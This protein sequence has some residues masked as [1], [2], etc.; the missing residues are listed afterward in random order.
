[1]AR[2]CGGWRNPLDRRV[3]RLADRLEVGAEL[4]LL[5][6]GDR[7]VVERRAPVGGALVHGQ[8]RDLVGDGR[9]QLH[10][11]RPGAD[12]RRR[13][14]RRSRPASAG[15]RPV[16]C[17]SPRKSSRPGTSGKYGTESTPV[18]AMRKRARNSVPSPAVT[19]HVADALVV[20]GRG[21]PGAEA[22]VAAEVEPVDHVVEVALGL[23]LLGEVL[24]PLPLVE[25][26]LREQVARTCSSPSRTGRRGSGSSTRCR[27]RRRRPRAAAR[28]SP[29]RARGTAGRC[30]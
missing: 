14:C 30:R 13:A 3:Q 2:S 27:R 23:R 7:R 1:M 20:H 11:A 16:W 24:L 28:R 29:L 22:D 17:D 8:R 18:A 25:Q 9:D 5:V 21:D 19:V 10:A 4:R 15:H 26:L 12:R 6:G